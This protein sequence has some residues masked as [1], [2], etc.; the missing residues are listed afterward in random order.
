[1]FL[2]ASTYDIIYTKYSYASNGFPSETTLVAGATSSSAPVITIDPSTND[3]YVFAATKTT[4]TPSGWTANH[5]Y[6]IK[7]SASSGTWGSWTDW[8]DESSEVLY[9][10][11]RLTGFYQAYCNY[12]G[13]AY[14]TKTSSPYN[15]KFASILLF[16]LR[17][18]AYGT[19]I[20]FAENLTASNIQ[21]FNDKIILINASLGSEPE[22]ADVT[23]AVKNAN[24]T[25]SQLSHNKQFIAELNGPTGTLAELTITHSLYQTMPG[26]V[27][28]AGLPLTTPCSTKEDFDKYVGNT[29]YYDT[30]TNTVYVKAILHSPTSIYVD[31]NPPPAP[32][33]PTP[34]PTPTPTPPPTPTTP[35]W[36]IILIIA[37][38]TVIGYAALKRRR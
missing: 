31:W 1:V 14:L 29:W 33:V 10:A 22:K 21:C 2:K 9:S 6:Y 16:P 12:I 23:I 32:I 24:L 37:V 18:P 7:Y 35:S 4:G 34:T 27:A 8:I 30:A 3:L 26:T 36:L 38:A 28:V 19:T 13:L 17:L 20:S 11:D 5:I 15:V 25:V